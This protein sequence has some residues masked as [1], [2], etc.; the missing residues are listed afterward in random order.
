MDALVLRTEEG[1]TRRAIRVGELSR[2]FDPAISEWGNPASF[3][4]YTGAKMSCI[5]SLKTGI[6]NKP[7][8][9]NYKFPIKNLYLFVFI[10]NSRISEFMPA[11]Q[12]T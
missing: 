5:V 8:N 10:W 9:T 7:I 11:V 12:D 6:S 1:R 4:G 3:T 2:S